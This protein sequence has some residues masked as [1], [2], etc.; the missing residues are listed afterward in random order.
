[1]KNLAKR[2]P[3]PVDA[4]SGRARTPE[5]KRPADGGRRGGEKVAE[6]GTNRLRTTAQ[7]AETDH[8]WLGKP[9]QSQMLSWVPEAVWP[10]GMSM[11]R[12]P[13]AEE[14]TKVPSA[15]RSAFHCW[16]LPPQ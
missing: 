9:R 2:P 11:T 4:G 10:P 13:L 1:M 16:Q 8:F 12:F 3:G 5:R 14:K 15:Q 6:R 7:G